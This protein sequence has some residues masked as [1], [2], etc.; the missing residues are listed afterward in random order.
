MKY[1][2]HAIAFVASLVM[3][4][5]ATAAIEV[6]ASLPQT[7]VVDYA[8]KLTAEE[9]V[10][11]SEKLHAY[12]RKTSNV[13]VVVTI[14]SLKE[15]GQ[16]TLQDWNMKLAD[17]WKPGSA[18]K[19]NGLIMTVLGKSAPYKVRINPGRGLTGVITDAF[20]KRTIEDTMKPVLNRPDGYYAG[21]NVAIDAVMA[22]IGNEFTVETPVGA[23]PKFSAA[24]IAL[25][26]LAALCAFLLGLISIWFSGVVGL[27]AG[28]LA[29]SVVLASGL[30]STI[31]GAII[32]LIIGLVLGAFARGFGGEGG[33][34]FGDFGGG[35]S[36]GGGGAEIDSG[37]DFDGGGGGD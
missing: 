12:H 5:G 4:G 16:P 36:S 2:L 14:P 35:I 18:K 8:G 13:L 11:L 31:L 7:L 19:D 22:K 26:V 29:T 3:F 30:G 25:V 1:V 27:V 37:G 23:K 34:G 10:A 24:A 28:A 32:G 6:P 21:I 33:G 9:Q 17:T 20:A 15:T